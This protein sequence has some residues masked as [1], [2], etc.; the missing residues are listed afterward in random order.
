VQE[1]VQTHPL[2]K[3]KEE[4]QHMVPQMVL[5]PGHPPGPAV[6]IIVTTV[7]V[8]EVPKVTPKIIPS[9]AAIHAITINAMYNGFIYL[10]QIIVEIS[11]LKNRDNFGLQTK[12]SLTEESRTIS[13]MCEI[14]TY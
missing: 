10:L 1:S 3:F 4:L 14:F 9:N 12:I 13:H 8:P 7:A 5:P 2:P 6:G 11:L